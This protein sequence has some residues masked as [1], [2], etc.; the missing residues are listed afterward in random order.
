MKIMAILSQYYQKF[1]S[2]QYIRNGIAEATPFKS[3]SH[4]QLVNNFHPP[5]TRKFRNLLHP[6]NRH[7]PNRSRHTHNRPHDY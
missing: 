5:N 7:V 3:I 6:D 1:P 4:Y 2:S